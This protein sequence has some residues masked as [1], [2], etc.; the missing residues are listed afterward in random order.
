MRSIFAAGLILLVGCPGFGDKTLAELSGITPDQMGDAPTWENSIKMILEERCGY[1]HLNP[2]AN[3]APSGFV[4]TKYDATDG[5]DPMEQGAFE[6][7]DRILA[8]AVTQ[9]TM[10]PSGAMNGPLLEAERV[11]IQQWA[12]AGAPRGA[13]AP[14]WDN[15]VKA[16][17]TNRCGNCHMSPQAN[18]APS[19]FVLIKY[20]AMDG[21]DPMEEGAFEKRERVDARA[22]TGNTMPP[23]G[24]MNG[25]LNDTEKATISLWLMNG[26]PRN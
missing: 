8:R 7:V 13:V 5:G 21:G 11:M 2:Q 12:D 25:P 15:T 9:S 10:P 16:I 14:T 18:G 24:A 4:F 19:G 3:G 1:C 22:V 20:D 23:S 6:K 17:L 26:A